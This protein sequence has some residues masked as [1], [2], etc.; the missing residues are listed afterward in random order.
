VYYAEYLRFLEEARTEY[1]KKKGVSVKDTVCGR[2]VFVVNRQEIDY[3]RPAFY[4]TYSV[5][6]RA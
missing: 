6:L 5:L 2:Y 4:G 1:L 3:Y